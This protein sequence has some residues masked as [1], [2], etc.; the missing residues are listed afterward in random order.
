MSMRT[1]LAAA[2]VAA[3]LLAGCGAGST[4]DHVVAV[5]TPTVSADPM[6]LVGMW[7]LQVDGKDAGVL[8]VAEEMTLFQ[9]CGGLEASWEAS[10]DG[11][12]IAFNAGGSSSCYTGNVPQLPTWVHAAR[13]FR[14]D[15]DTRVLV[16]E[17]GRTL[18][19][20]LPGG[21]PR[22]P[23]TMSAEYYSTVPTP[24]AQLAKRMA[25]PAPL[26]SALTA[27]TETTLTRR[28]QAPDN[29]KAYLEF[30]AD[31]SFSGSDGCNGEGGRWSLGPSGELLTVSGGHT[32]IGCG[33]SQAGSWLAAA[34]RAG[35][36]G[37]QL[38]LLD[39]DA[40]ELGRLRAS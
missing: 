20:L 38:V 6:A 26:P 39:A 36:D 8:R 22:I 4:P 11:G 34:A 18:V 40:H 23:S 7:K 19:T 10:H 33:N 13:G 27:A 35:I 30:H 5:P 2:V 16:D 29:A 31:A 25:E 9:D 24:S 21:K 28:W 12:F 14:V 32:L 3:G 17:A 1:C 15:G 37:D